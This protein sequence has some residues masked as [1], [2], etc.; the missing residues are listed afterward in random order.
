MAV[1]HFLVPGPPTPAAAKP[2][3][4]APAA[5]PPPPPAA[6]AAPQPMTVKAMAHAAPRPTVAPVILGED[7]TE[8]IKG[9][10]KAMVIVCLNIDGG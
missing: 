2:A 1:L 10:W 3:A 5:P 8:P 9:I 6:P 4:P 7:K